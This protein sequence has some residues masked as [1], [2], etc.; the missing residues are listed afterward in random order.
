MINDVSK[1]VKISRTQQDRNEFLANGYRPASSVFYQLVD[2]KKLHYYTHWIF[3]ADEGSGTPYY[4]RYKQDDQTFQCLSE[5]LDICNKHNIKCVLYITPAHALLDGEG[6][7]VSGLWDEMEAFKRK[8]TNISAAHN[9]ALWDFS[10]YNYITTEKVQSPM[11][12]YWDASHFTEAVGDLMMEQMLMP[13]SQNTAYFGR[14]ITPDNIDDHLALIRK[15][16]I[17]YLQT[18]KDD[19]EWLNGIYAKIKAHEAIPKEQTE[20]IFRQ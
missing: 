7:F 4:G 6:I 13:D 9:V 16:R 14:K 19:V 20:G 12:Y 10:G 17:N 8:V 3:L 5:F 1:T 18:G 2:Y 11:N 15:D